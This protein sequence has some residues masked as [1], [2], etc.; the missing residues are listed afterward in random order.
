M[1]FHSHPPRFEI[2]D[3]EEPHLTHTNAQADPNVTVTSLGYNTAEAVPMTVYYRKSGE[4]SSRPT[5]DDLRHG[6]VEKPPQVEL[7]AT[8]VG[9]SCGPLG[10]GLAVGPPGYGLAVGH[11]GMG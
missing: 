3:V 11:R 6:R 10:Y 9:V 5:L 7:Q 1:H 4:G 2:E 8:G